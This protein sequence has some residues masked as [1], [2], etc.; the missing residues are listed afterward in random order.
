MLNTFNEGGSLYYFIQSVEEQDLW[1]RLREA[2]KRN[3]PMIGSTADRQDLEE[4]GLLSTHTYSL[5]DCN[6]LKGRRM[7]KCRNPWGKFEWKGELSD[8]DAFWKELTKE[9]LERAGASNKDDGT[10]FIPYEQFY[11][12]FLSIDIGIIHRGYNYIFQNF[13]KIGGAQYVQMEVDQEMDMYLM[14]NFEASSIKNKCTLLLA[15]QEGRAFTYTD[16]TSFTYFSSTKLHAQRLRPGSYVVFIKIDLEQNENVKLRNKVTYTLAT[17]SSGVPKLTAVPKAKFVKEY[18]DFLE[19]T[20]LSHA[21]GHLKNEPHVDKD[22]YLASNFMIDQ[23]DFGYIFAKLKEGSAGKLTITM[24]LDMLRAMGVHPIRAHKNTKGTYL[25]VA[26]DPGKMI[27]I[28]ARMKYRTALEDIQ[29]P[30]IDF[31]VKRIF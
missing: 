28:L 6:E 18:P 11:K 8:S 24:N 23:G 5:I 3:L 14:V 4:L 9:E 17:Y 22:W 29:F 1:R 15:R 19:Q 27:I 31:I 20:L 12:Y 25:R 7:V 26:G 13:E 30:P 21:M 2:S 16:A 10:F